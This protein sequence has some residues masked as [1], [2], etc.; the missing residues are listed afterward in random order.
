VRDRAAL[1]KQANYRVQFDVR[2]AQG[3]LGFVDTTSSPARVGIGGLDKPNLRIRIPSVMLDAVLAGRVS[4][5]EVLISFRLWFDESP[6]VYHE[7][8]WALLHSSNRLDPER[9]L[10]ALQGQGGGKRS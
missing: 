8:W 10:T 1:A 7:P 9:Y 2:G 4:W 5:D 6:P 3:F